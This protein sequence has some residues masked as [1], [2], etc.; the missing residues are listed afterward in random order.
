MRDE[1]IL[2][3]IWLAERCG[4]A[5]KDVGRL[6]EKYSDP[7]DVYRLDTEELER[8]DGISPSLKLKLADK[9]LEEAY[10]TLRYCRQKKIDVISYESDRYPSRLRPL[11]DPPA[12]LFVKGKMPDLNNRLCI[13]M[14]GTRKMSE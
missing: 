6:V 14:V 7:Y 12:V 2:Y 3:W 13:A 9:S 10:S 4:P 11:E 8:V 1:S 5:S